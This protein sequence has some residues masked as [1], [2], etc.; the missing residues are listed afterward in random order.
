MH[1]CTVQRKYYESLDFAQWLI[2]TIIKAFM[3]SYLKKKKLSSY[4]ASS[5]V[6]KGSTKSQLRRYFSDYDFIASP[7][8]VNENHW[9]LLFLSIS[10]V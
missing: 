5:I 7:A 1:L 9:A 10:S 8:H 2:Y 4:Q 3:V 6:T